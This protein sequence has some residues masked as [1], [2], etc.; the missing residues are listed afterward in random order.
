MTHELNVPVAHRH[1]G[2]NLNVFARSSLMQSSFLRHRLSAL[3]VNLRRQE[4]CMSWTEVVVPT[5]ERSRDAAS[6]DASLVQPRWPREQRRLHRHGHHLT[7]K[8][9]AAALTSAF[10]VSS[11]LCPGWSWCLEM[12]GTCTTR[13]D[14]RQNRRTR[15]ARVPSSLWSMRGAGS[16]L[17]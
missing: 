7:M 1:V 9:P 11:S 10:A 13:G 17:G 2:Y 14:K 12:S 3:T 6:Q 8:L 16:Y 5:C 4:R 15:T